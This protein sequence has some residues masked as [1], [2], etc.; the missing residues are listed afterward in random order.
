M[1]AVTSVHS[2]VLVNYLVEESQASNF[3]AL[4][5]G[6]PTKFL[7]EARG[8]PR[9]ATV[10]STDEPGSMALDH[11]N[12]IDIIFEVR[13]PD[14]TGVFELWTDQAFVCSLFDFRF[15]VPEVSS[16]Q[17]QCSVGLAYYLVDVAWPRE[18]VTDGHAKVWEDFNS[19]QDTA[20]HAVSEG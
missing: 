8:D 1:R 2:N 19:L 5:Q 17:A 16:Q 10:V 9:F 13:I 15:T 3:P 7:E 20:V 14:C 18:V 11:F 6:L 4:L 12:V